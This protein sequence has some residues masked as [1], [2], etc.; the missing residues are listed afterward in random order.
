[1]AD[2][3]T[4]FPANEVVS[5]ENFN[6][7]ITQTNTALTNMKNSIDNHKA[8]NKNPHKT[9][10]A[11]V[12]GK[13]KNL[14]RNWYWARPVNQRSITTQ[15]WDAHNIDGWLTY[16]EGTNTFT[17][18]VVPGSH[19]HMAAGNHWLQQGQRYEYLPNG[20]YTMS[21]KLL[22]GTI[23]SVSVPWDNNTAVGIDVAEGLGLF[24]ANSIGYPYFHIAIGAGH[25]FDIVAVKIEEGTVSTLANDPPPNPQQE[26]AKCQ[27]FQ[28]IANAVK[29]P[30]AFFGQ[31]VAW[32]D[33]SFAIIECQIPNLRTY[34]ACSYS[35][36]LVLFDLAAPSTHSVTSI[37]A[38]RGAVS[39]SMLL[40]VSASG[41]TAG[42]FYQLI[43]D[44]DP[45]ARIIYDANL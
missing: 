43:S 1:M 6:S 16:S 14:A 13:N 11:Q 40:K 23:H 20:V 18:E 32:T 42:K 29:N 27:W 34:P 37:V 45:N 8:D 5:R 33:G 26:T 36:N 9:T 15:V 44:N 12:G 38:E 24:L 28:Y 17:L 39:G 22:N 41:I 30:Y 31:G 35:G 10:L 25:S 3:I 2:F 21:L 7:R 4:Q 19:L